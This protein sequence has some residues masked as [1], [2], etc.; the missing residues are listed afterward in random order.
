MLGPAGQTATNNRAAAHVVD[1]KLGVSNGAD[2]VNITVKV[3]LIDDESLNTK[4]I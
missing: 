3:A 4:L 2:H 1:A